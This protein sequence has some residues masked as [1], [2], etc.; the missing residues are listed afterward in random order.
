M[1]EHHLVLIGCIKAIK[2]ALSS[3]HLVVGSNSFQEVQQ[4]IIGLR[5]VCLPQHSIYLLAGYGHKW[6]LESQVQAYPLAATGC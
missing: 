2:I 4:T 6:D 1:V 5:R 3:D